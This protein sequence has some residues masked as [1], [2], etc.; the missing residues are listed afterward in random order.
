MGYLVFRNKE[1]KILKDCYA[2]IKH[3]RTE[4]KFRRI[5][6]YYRIWLSTAIKLPTN[7]KLNNY[8]ED[9]RNRLNDYELN[10]ASEEA[11]INAIKT[12]S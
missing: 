4:D 8:I 9:A 7:P 6:Q 10:K 1:N 5:Y 12:N 11:F 3:T 2:G